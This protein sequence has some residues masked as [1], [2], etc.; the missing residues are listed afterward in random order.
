M[1]SGDWDDSD[2]ADTSG[3]RN[4]TNLPAMGTITKNASDFHYIA[5]DDHEVIHNLER[6][7]RRKSRKR[8]AKFCWVSCS[9]RCLIIYI[10]HQFAIQQVSV[11]HRLF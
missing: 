8:G 11:S 10:L 6:E 3:Q 4:K 7:L 5:R 1:D 2:I 9:L